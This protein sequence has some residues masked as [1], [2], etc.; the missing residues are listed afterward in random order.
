MNSSAPAA[1]YAGADVTIQA[2]IDQTG[3]GDDS[4]TEVTEAYDEPPLHG[5][6]GRGERNR[7][8]VLRLTARHPRQSLSV[9][10]ISEPIG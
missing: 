10:H 5:G 3:L 6:R 7:S 9:P 1:V 4:G 8:A 2:G